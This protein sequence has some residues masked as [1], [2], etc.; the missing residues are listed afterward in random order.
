MDARVRVSP[1]ELRDPHLRW[2]PLPALKFEEDVYWLGNS[3]V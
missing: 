2:P 3:Y 1:A